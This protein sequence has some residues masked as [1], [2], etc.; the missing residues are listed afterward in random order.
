[1]LLSGG[2]D[3]NAA[4]S[5]Y[6]QTAFM[7]AAAERQPAV[8]KLLIEHGADV[9]ARSNS[10]FSTLMFAAQQGDAESGRALLEA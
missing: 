9:S 1:M 7:W 10:G 6:G 3:P 4:E 5:K 8:T 2:A